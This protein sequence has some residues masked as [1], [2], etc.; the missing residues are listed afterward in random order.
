MRWHLCRGT[1]RWVLLT[2]RWAIKFPSLARWNAFVYGLVANMQEV[3]F[4]ATGRPELC[5]V[6]WHMPGAFVT[7]MPR[8]VPLTAAEF[9]QLDY[10]AFVDHEGYHFFVEHKID[11]F[12]WWD[13]QLVAIDYA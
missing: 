12:G 4:S 6:V 13:G 9:E 7:V 8:I 11:S 2:R 5:P 3:A 10:E 1:T